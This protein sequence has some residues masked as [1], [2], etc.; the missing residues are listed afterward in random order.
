MR[1]ATEQWIKIAEDDL[2]TA[3][4]LLD[5]KKYLESMFFCQ[6]SV[7]KYL[8]SIYQEENNKTPPRVHD[9]VKLAKLLT[10][11]STVLEEFQ[12]LLIILSEYYIETRYPKERI[13]LKEQLNP[14]YCKKTY[15]EVK[16]VIKCLQQIV[17]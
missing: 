13:R 10:D 16:E 6:Q 8:K 14:R 15:Q 4:I 11:T 1:K 2:D 9:L 12:N 3:G 17:G 5:K 7:E